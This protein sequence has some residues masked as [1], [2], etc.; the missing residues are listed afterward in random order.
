ML[1]A[2]ASLALATQTALSAPLASP[3]AVAAFTLIAAAVLTKYI[4]T[5]MVASCRIDV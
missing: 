4:L 3:A 2:T 1:V 5:G